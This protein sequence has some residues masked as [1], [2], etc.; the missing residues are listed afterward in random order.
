MWQESR[1]NGDARQAWL[2]YEPKSSAG[3][4]ATSIGV[5]LYPFIYIV[6]DAAMAPQA[7]AAQAA[8]LAPRQE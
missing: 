2:A 1:L 5:A 6:T 7:I 4:T 8:L 3:E